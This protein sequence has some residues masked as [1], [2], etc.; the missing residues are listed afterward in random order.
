[1]KPELKTNLDKVLKVLEEKEDL[2]LILGDWDEGLKLEQ[3]LSGKDVSSRIEAARGKYGD[4]FQWR[5]FNREVDV[6]WNGETGVI[7]KGE[8]KNIKQFFLETDYR[9]FPGTSIFRQLEYTCI[10]VEEIRCEDRVIYLR[11]I[12]LSKGGKQ[13][14]DLQG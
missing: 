7:C 9:R 6:W 11:M 12:E 8:S 14:E 2:T 4:R 3:G 13:D 10:E 5:A 1:M